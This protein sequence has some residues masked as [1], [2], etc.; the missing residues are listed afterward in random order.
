MGKSTTFRGTLGVSLPWVWESAGVAGIPVGRD[1]SRQSESHL[2][3]EQALVI[4][5]AG[6]PKTLKVLP[7][8][9]FFQIS[10]SLL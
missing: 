6:I 7:T 10:D 2:E 1:Q 8:L 5:K 3:K 4:A 9:R